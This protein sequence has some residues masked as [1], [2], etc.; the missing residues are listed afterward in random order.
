MYYLSDYINN[1]DMIYN[2]FNDI[3]NNK[4]YNKY[5]IYFHN[6]AKFDS[7]FLIKILNKNFNLNKIIIKDNSIISLNIKNKNIQLNIKDSYLMLN[8][9][10]DKLCKSFNVKTK[11][12][13][14]KYDIINKYNL[15]INKNQSLNYLKNDL[16]S[17]YEVL[18][19]FNLYV[20]NKTN[21]NINNYK[22][23]SSLA[24]NVYLSNYYNLTWDIKY[25]EKDIRNSYYGGIVDVYKPYVKNGYYYDMNS[26]Y[27]YQM[28]NYDMPTGNP[29]YSYDN[30]LNNYFGFCYANI[31][32]PKNILIPILPIKING[33]L[34]CPLGSFK[35][36]YFS[37]E[38]KF[39]RDNGYKIEILGGII[40]IKKIYLKIM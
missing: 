20:F 3:L 31:I 16:I 23:I 2:C 29:I 11:K 28:L 19:K 32:T 40:L 27:P 22:T 15:K 36:W 9:S 35:G 1:D 12:L 10:L 38:L 37:E 7:L 4:K 33:K 6:F 5:T 39:A 21:L 14:F 8:Q 25:I 26:Q 30:D 17:L 18:I 13:T 24:Y 34:I